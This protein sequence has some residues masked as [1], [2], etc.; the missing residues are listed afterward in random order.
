MSGLGRVG[1]LAA[2]ALVH[3]AVLPDLVE[4]AAS[5]TQLAEERHALGTTTGLLELGTDLVDR[6]HGVAEGE[7]VLA[8]GAGLDA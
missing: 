8:V 5:T 3:L 1:E 4:A 7:A 6:C 2:P